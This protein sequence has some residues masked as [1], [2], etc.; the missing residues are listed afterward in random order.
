MRR[1]PASEPALRAVLWENVFLSAGAQKGTHLK[2]TTQA[3]AVTQGDQSSSDKESGSVSRD[4]VVAAYRSFLG[5]EPENEAV[6]KQK[7]EAC[8]S[9]E[10]LLNAFLRSPEFARRFA[11]YSAVVGAQYTARQQPVDIEVPNEQF[12]R[13]FSRVKEQWTALG[14]SEPYWSVLADDRF[15]MKSIDT[16][17]TDFYASGALSDRLIDIFCQRTHIAPPSGTCLELGCGVGRVTRFLARRFNRVL[18]VD[19]SEGN[20]E[21]AQ[22]YL[23]KERVDNVSWLLL[24]ELEQLQQV[25]EF[26]FFYS[27]LVLQHN[28]PPV[29]A[30]MLK[31]IL[32]KLRRG[33]AF[34]FQVPNQTP[35]YTFSTAAYLERPN[36][37]GTTYEM[38][39]LP[40]YAV[41]DI[42]AEA[43]GRTKEV[44]ADM[45]TGGYGSHTFFGTK[46]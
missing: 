23:R 21:L 11:N 4:L 27:I 33:G 32:G 18:G 25:E 24:R 36:K 46:N 31:L 37:A 38:H 15:R 43:G 1:S 29:I 3:P 7:V 35:G 26:D 12:D 41:L 45:L 6:V 42:I 30:R 13:L 39:A 19:I 14:R 17:L 5:R 44:M 20:L 34:L 28:P 10:Q 9:E 40:M 22:S 16:N 2:S 8:R